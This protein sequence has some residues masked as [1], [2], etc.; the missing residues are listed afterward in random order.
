MHFHVRT[1][2]RLGVGSTFLAARR[3]SCRPSCVYEGDVD[4]RDLIDLRSAFNLCL[5]AHEDR[6]S[7]LYIPEYSD[8]M[9]PSRQPSPSV[10]FPHRGSWALLQGRAGWLHGPACPSYTGHRDVAR[11]PMDI[12]PIDLS[13]VIGSATI[14]HYIQGRSSLGAGPTGRRRLSIISYIYT[15]LRTTVTGVSEPRQRRRRQSVQEDETRSSSQPGRRSRCRSG[16]T[17]YLD[18]SLCLR[19]RTEFL[20]DLFS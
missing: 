3:R 14:D 18:R 15:Y 17:T 1:T 16:I 8:P 6:A 9:H 12:G 11:G 2:G 19:V 20:L 13:I 4:R 10:F 7:R 5:V